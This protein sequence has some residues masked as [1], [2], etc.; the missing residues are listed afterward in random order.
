MNSTAA[1]R[2]VSSTRI[3]ASAGSPADEIA[4]RMAAAMAMLEAMADDEPRRKAVLP[5]F[6][7]RPAASE[8]T[9]GRL[10]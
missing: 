9:L 7:H 3:R 4:S 10:S 5:D 6:R 8:V 2:D 1:A